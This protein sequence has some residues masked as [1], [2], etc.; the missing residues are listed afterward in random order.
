MDSRDGIGFQ[1]N[2]QIYR[3]L[4]LCSQPDRIQIIDS[5]DSSILWIANDDC[6]LAIFCKNDAATAGIQ[7]KKFGFFF[8]EIFF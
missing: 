2:S 3:R 8:K 7:S 4:F 6:F 5:N 1:I